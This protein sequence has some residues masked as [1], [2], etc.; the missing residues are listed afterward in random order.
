MVI[1]ISKSL[2]VYNSAF[3]HEH[4][5]VPFEAMG[6]WPRLGYVAYKNNDEPESHNGFKGL[7]MRVKGHIFYYSVHAQL[8]QTRRF[9][10]RH[11]TVVIAVVVEATKELVMEM[12]YKGDFGFAAVRKNPKGLLSVNAQDELIRTELKAMGNQGKRTVNVINPANLNPDHL[13]KPGTSLLK[14]RYEIWVLQPLCVNEAKKK[15]N[16]VVDF[17][18]AAT[19]LKESGSTEV[20]KLGRAT[21]DHVVYEKFNSIKR[22]FKTDNIEIGAAFCKYTQPL[23]ADGVFYTDKL[24]TSLV[25]KPPPNTASNIA[26]PQFVKPGFSLKIIG[27]Y[28]A[29]DTWVGMHI[30]GFKGRMSD[31]GRAIIPEE[32]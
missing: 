18:N 30:K 10:A 22:D 27:R 15:K 32:N 11:H 9:T 12:G 6:Y 29:V 5:S 3:D 21:Q 7:M 13:Y 25:P 28:M 19:A 16:I 26:L 23:P 1:Y 8:S 4:G 2:F 24:G 31:A 14:G 17:K 20:Q